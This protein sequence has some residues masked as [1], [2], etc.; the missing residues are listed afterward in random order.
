MLRS[1]VVFDV[2]ACHFDTQIVC[3]EALVLISLSVPRGF[4][5]VVESRR[6]ILANF[7]TKAKLAGPTLSLLSR[8]SQRKEMP[9]SRLIL[10]S[11]TFVGIVIKGTALIFI[12][13][14]AIDQDV[15]AECIF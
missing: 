10:C 3:R 1:T 11:K 12:S 15:P 4:N 13:T 6:D 8:T 9:Y 2:A 14:V 7:G 5:L